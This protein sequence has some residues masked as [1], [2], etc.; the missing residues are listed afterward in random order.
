MYIYIYIC[1]YVY[2]SYIFS[3][4]KAVSYMTKFDNIFDEVIIFLSCW[5]I[6][7]KN[8]VNL[9]KKVWII[10]V[11]PVNNFG[12]LSQTIQRNIASLI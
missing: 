2:I 3:C 1:I 8:S 11:V 4:S 9:D 10:I 7:C 12:F 5:Y 6:F